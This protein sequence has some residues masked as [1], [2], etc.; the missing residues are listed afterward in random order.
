MNR[1]LFSVSAAVFAATLCGGLF[2]SVPLVSAHFDGGT[3]IS[4]Y[5]DQLSS[6]LHFDN[7]EHTE[8]GEVGVGLATGVLSFRKAAASGNSTGTVL[9]SFDKALSMRTPS[10]IRA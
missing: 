1:I 6:S 4:A 9:I 10:E 3:M 7:A 8:P 2:L 5:T